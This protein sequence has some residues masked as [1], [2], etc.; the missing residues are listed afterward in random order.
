MGGA[1]AF[2]DG[3][4]DER[5]SPLDGIDLPGVEPT[6]FRYLEV[7]HAARLGG[8]AFGDVILGKHLPT[9]ELCALK[10]VPIR[11]SPPGLD[12][13]LPANVI[14]EL[15]CMRM[16]SGERNVVRLMDHFASGRALVLA[17]ELCER[18]DLATA[19]G[20][21]FGD[22]QGDRAASTSRSPLSDACVKSLIHQVL[23]GVAACHRLGVLHRDVKPGN[24]LIHASGVLKLADFGLAAAAANAPAAA[25]A[26]ATIRLGGV[27]RGL[28][29]CRGRSGASAP[30]KRIPKV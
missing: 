5:R 7:P 19:L 24:V 20:H 17:M 16:V 2:S 26:T 21:D 22:E 12:D 4:G 14:S 28:Y 6:R 11:E 8:G 29:G 13:A 30:P 27:I 9:G 10:R 25:R 1:G 18:G 3:H 23:S 15:Q